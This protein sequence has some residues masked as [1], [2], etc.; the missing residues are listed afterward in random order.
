MW[1]LFIPEVVSKAQQTG[2]VFCRGDAK[3]IGT[4]ALVMMYK[5]SY[6]PI[7]AYNFFSIRSSL[8]TAQRHGTSK[9]INRSELVQCINAVVTAC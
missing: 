5:T 6:K 9:T 4:V 1:S 8:L 3:K 7:E 2:E